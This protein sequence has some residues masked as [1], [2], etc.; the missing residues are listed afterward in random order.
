MALA[1]SALRQTLSL[2]PDD[3]TAFAKLQRNYESLLTLLDH[4]ERQKDR[5]RSTAEEAEA[6]RVAAE[7]QVS[8]LKL[9]NVELRSRLR[10]LEADAPLYADVFQQYEDDLQRQVRELAALRAENLAV[11]QR[12]VSST[13]PIVTV[14]PVTGRSAR[15]AA[16]KTQVRK[17]SEDNEA[18]SGELHELRRVSR[19]YAVNQRA[20][21]DSRLRVN[22]L[23][24]HARGI[25]NEVVAVKRAQDE[26]AQQA[27]K[28]AETTADKDR[29][30][31]ELR[32]VLSTVVAE[33]APVRERI[34][35]RLTAGA[36]RAAE[37]MPSPSGKSVTKAEAKRAAAARLEVGPFAALLSAINE[38]RSSNRRPTRDPSGGGGG[39]LGTGSC[40]VL[41]RRL[42]RQV[43]GDARLAALV[44]K[45]ARAVDEL[46]RRVSTWCELADEAVHESRADRATLLSSEEDIFKHIDNVLDVL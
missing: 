29:T 41:V 34:R 45:I 26:T 5:H 25:E 23:M 16:L 6:A 10:K 9:E 20:L 3:P 31:N 42:A 30:I 12:Y 21:T 40:Q 8:D 1:K 22:N 43:E 15:V 37:L 7:L 28:L 32:T 18:L 38:T 44:E 33:L 36:K 14:K 19:Q 24:R 46:D 17:L 35:E 4:E 11:F 2:K 13:D 39:A 27:A